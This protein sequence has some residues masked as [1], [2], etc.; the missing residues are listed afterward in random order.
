MLT[1]LAKEAAEVAP[2]P[3]CG[4]CLENPEKHPNVQH[5]DFPVLHLLGNC[6]GGDFPE[7]SAKWGSKNVGVYFHSPVAPL[8][9]PVPGACD[10]FLSDGRFYVQPPG[11]PH[12]WMEAPREKY[13]SGCPPAWLPR[14]DKYD[15]I[16]VDSETTKSHLEKMGVNI[17][18]GVLPVAFNVELFQPHSGPEPF[19]FEV[20]QEGQLDYTELFEDRFVIYSV[21]FIIS[22]SSVIIL[23]SL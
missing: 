19:K 5:L 11:M 15:L 14:A 12:E 3:L 13:I 9:N 16:L 20:K 23:V 8:H 4:D 1:K 18:V 7:V 6:V 21:G 17:P 22:S 10:R 2:D